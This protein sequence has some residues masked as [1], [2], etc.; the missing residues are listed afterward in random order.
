M[1]KF[2][3]SQRRACRLV[4]VDPKTVRRERAPDHPEIRV[5]AR[6]AALTVLKMKSIPRQK[7]RTL[8][9]RSRGARLHGFVRAGFSRLGPPG[10]RTGGNRCR[11]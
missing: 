10:R 8:S 11:S 1:S 4:G 5:Y 9:T 2:E 7:I 6:V 3:I